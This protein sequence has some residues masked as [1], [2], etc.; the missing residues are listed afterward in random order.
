MEELCYPAQGISTDGPFGIYVIVKFISVHVLRST[1]PFS[2]WIV[3]AS[4]SPTSRLVKHGVLLGDTSHYFVFL[5]A[6][7]KEEAGVV[8]KTLGSLGMDRGILEGE[9]DN[10]YVYAFLKKPNTIVHPGD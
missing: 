9:S 2:N 5:R 4:G 6:R 3:G 8:I 7:S 10:I 1:E